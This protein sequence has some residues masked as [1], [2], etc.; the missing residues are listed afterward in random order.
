MRAPYLA[1]LLIVLCGA[2][3]CQREEREVRP[4]PAAVA[5][6]D[7]RVALSTITAGPAAPVVETS[8]K[9]R[10]YETNAYHL[11]QGKTLYKWFNCNG[12]HANG[13]GDSGPPL[14]DD[15]WIYGGSIEN[16]V[17]AIREGRPNG[18]PSFRGRIPDPQIWEIAAY[19]RSMSGNVPAAAA[20]S[21][22]DS[23]HARPAENRQTP[24]PPV[25]GGSTPPSGLMP[26]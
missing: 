21:R 9:G 12:C 22:S 17:A 15:K 7:E 25:P 6:T 8:G 18:M 23:L 19:V 13:G 16:I 14:M 3:P 24:S 20:P 2:G 10:D 26:E 11:S 5:E 4:D 1:P